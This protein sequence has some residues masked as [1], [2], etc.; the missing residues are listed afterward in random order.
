MD[1]L[2]FT[3]AS[4]ETLPLPPQGK[5]KYYRDGGSPKS[6]RGL[7]VCVLA[8]GK[9][10]FY[11]SRWAHGKSQRVRL[12]AFPEMSIEQA[13]KKAMAENAAIEAGRDPS[14]DRAAKREEWTFG[15]LFMWWMDTHAK[16]R[17]KT[18]K[19]DQAVYDRYLTGLGGV[20]LSEVTKSELRQ[21]HGG[22]GK[23]HGA[24][25]ANKALE[26]VRAVFG[27]AIKH[28]RFERANPVLGVEMYE[29][30]TRDR[31]L[32]AHEVAKFFEVLD[33]QAEPYMRD[34][35]YLSLFTGQRQA[36]VLAMRWDQIDWPGKVWR[37][38]ESKNGRPVSV[39]LLDV[40]LQ[41]LEGRKKEVG[42]SPWVFPSPRGSTSGHMEEPKKGWDTI[43]KKAGIPDLRI[44]DLRRSLGSWMVDAGAT[45]PVIGQALGHQ[46]QAATAIY[47]RLS[48]DPV[49]EAKERAIGAML[50]KHSGS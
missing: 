22:L 11:L 29:R 43:R 3:K 20:P 25:T 39:P 28:D 42:T 2:N 18:Y 23:T 34:Y 15:E 30:P 46:S 14:A 7:E 17:R 40:E 9:R 13:R 50:S 1:Q 19:E 24:R 6:V 8:N 44:H 41:L 35:I 49:R 5:R 38:P 37:V 4:I 12:G 26:L 45:L 47:A 33:S 21:L 36:N 31:R 48:L 32:M 16:L 10:T 27:Q